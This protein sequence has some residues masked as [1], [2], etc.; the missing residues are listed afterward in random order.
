[1][2]TRAASLAAPRTEAVASRQEQRAE[3]VAQKLQH[4]LEAAEKR[5]QA[6]M[7]AAKERLS[8]AHELVFARM[9]RGG[10]LQLY[11]HCQEHKLL[12]SSAAPTALTAGV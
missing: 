8:A 5:R 6:R 4:N 9:V 3:E 1:M 7:D 2:R 12:C 11:P 10:H